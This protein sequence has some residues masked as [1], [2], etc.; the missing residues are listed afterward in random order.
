MRRMTENDKN[1]GP[2]TW[3]PWTKTFSLRWETSGEDEDDSHEYN[4]VRAIGFGYAIR[5][6]LPAIIKPYKEKHKALGWDAATIERMGRD[7]YYNVY[8]RE[9]GFSLSN[10]GSGYNFLSIYFGPQTHD[11][12]TTKSWCKTFPWT[13]WNCVR[14]SLYRPDGTHFFTEDSRNRSSMEFY[15]KKKECP[16]CYFEF[17]DYDGERIIATCVV[18]EMEWHKGYGW[19]KWLK[20]FCKPMIRRSLDLQFDSEVGPEK[21]SWKGGTIGHGIEM[22]VGESP[23]QA[24]RR[25][26][27]QEHRSKYRKFILKFIGPCDGPRNKAII[28]Q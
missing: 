3:G 25:Y 23:E 14:H 8:P 7:W 12:S 19:F 9:F 16:S 11:S 2:F 18:T 4:L 28:E 17:E 20:Y 22:L 1:W 21:G 10:L 24:F 6:R 15:D 13:E 27:H 26:C 5:L